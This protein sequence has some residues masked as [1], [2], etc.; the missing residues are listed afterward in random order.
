MSRVLKNQEESLLI[1]R[2][3]CKIVF[4]KPPMDDLHRV[5][6]IARMWTSHQFST[7]NNDL[8]EKISSHFQLVIWVLYG[9]C[10]GGFSLRYVEHAVVRFT[11]FQPFTCWQ[12]VHRLFII[13]DTP[14]NS[15]KSF[16]VTMVYGW[17]D[18]YD[19]MCAHGQFF[20]M[21]WDAKLRRTTTPRVSTRISCNVRSTT[22]INPMRVWSVLFFAM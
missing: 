11:Y 5:V 18:G 8:W 7:W 10:P 16:W 14:A 9:Q 21:T 3:H 15:D 12:H 20:R 4:Q 2:N 1:I 19:S 13:Y 17:M 22:L 6:G